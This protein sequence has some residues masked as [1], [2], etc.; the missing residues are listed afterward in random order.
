MRLNNISSHE[1]PEIDNFIKECVNEGQ[2]LL[3]KS[4]SIIDACGAAAYYLKAG[5]HIYALGDNGRVIEELNS[6]AAN[7]RIDE[8]YYFSD[9]PR[10]QSL[11]NSMSHKYG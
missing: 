8:L 10:P 7:F 4:S 2:W 11:S 5:D 9:L 1:L 3:F 6:H